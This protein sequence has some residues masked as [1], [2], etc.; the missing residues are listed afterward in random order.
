MASPKR[1]CLVA[2]LLTVKQQ[3]GKS[4]KSYPSQ[5][6]REQMTTNDKDKKITLAALLGE[7]WP[8]N[9]FMIE[10]V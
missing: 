1:R 7:I 9:S 2:Y 10:T 5:F 8:K 4:L 6:N 3:D